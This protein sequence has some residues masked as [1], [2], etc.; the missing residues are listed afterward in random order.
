MSSTAERASP[1]LAITLGLIGMVMFAGT[2][3]ATRLAVVGLDPVFITVGRAMLAGVLAAAVL[4][5]TRQP[6][7]QRRDWLTFAAIAACLVFGFPFFTGLAME[8]VPANHGSVV[9]AILPLATAAAAALVGGERPGRLFWALSVLGGVLVLV[10]S[11]SDAGWVLLA[12]DVYLIAAA[13]IAAT[14]YALSG[15]LSRR[16][17]GWAVVSWALVLSLPLTTPATVLTLP[18]VLPT[19]PSVW[20]GFVYLGAVSMLLGFFFWNSAMALGGIAKIGQ[21][22]LLQ[23]FVTMVLAT[24]VA[25]EAMEA[26]LAAYATAVVI[27]VAAAQRARVAGPLVAPPSSAA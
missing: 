10:F 7:P 6:L 19:S 17:P 21:I 18:A 13:A 1:V 16:M 9:L 4:A 14:G 12:G 15:R 27:V 2:L 5:A 11:L 3:P 20:A 23:P 8:K 24:L 26:H 22:Q 25:G